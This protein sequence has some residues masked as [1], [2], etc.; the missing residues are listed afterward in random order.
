MAKFSR[1]EHIGI[2]EARERLRVYKEK[3]QCY[4]AY[5]VEPQ[6]LDDPKLENFF[7]NTKI[8]PPTRK[9]WDDLQQ[10]QNR[11]LGNERKLLKHLNLSKKK[12]QPTY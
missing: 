7:K 2:C 5:L 4:P 9:M 10:L 6:T 3:I 11:L 1:E 8:P 12:Q